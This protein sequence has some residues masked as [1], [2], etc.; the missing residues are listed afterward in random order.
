M[1]YDDGYS[2]R[3]DKSVSA[4]NGCQGQRDLQNREGNIRKTHTPEEEMFPFLSSTHIG[5]KNGLD[6]Q[7]LP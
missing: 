2:A 1:D 4:I 3:N 6:T 7:C 5:D